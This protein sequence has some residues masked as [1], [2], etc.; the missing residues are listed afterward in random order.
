[1]RQGKDK[2]PEKVVKQSNKDL[3]KLGERIK[4]L[5]IKKGYSSYE[6]FAYDHNFSRTQFG[7]YEK[8]EDLRY[9]SL[10]RVIK[11]LEVSPDEFFKG[12][13]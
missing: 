7:R 13:L 3:I 6:V 12:L 8:G 2:K 10:I 11:A 4:E 1:M 9:T 5:R